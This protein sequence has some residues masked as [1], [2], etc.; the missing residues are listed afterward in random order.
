MGLWRGLGGIAGIAGMGGLTYKLGLRG[1]KLGVHGIGVGIHN[2]GVEFT[3][4]R[5]GKEKGGTIYFFKAF[6]LFYYIL[7]KL[8]NYPTKKTKESCMCCMGT[9]SRDNPI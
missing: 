9:T 1:G 6:F 5:V 4:L 7:R 3:G 8:Q 2:Q